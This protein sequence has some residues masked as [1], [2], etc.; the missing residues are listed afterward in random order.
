MT[1]RSY[2]DL[3]DSAT[4]FDPQEQFDR[5]IDE[6]MKG[7]S[8][9]EPSLLPCPFCGE[10]RIF[11][12]EPSQFFQ[13]GSINCPA[14][15]VVLPGA[16]SDADELIDLWNTRYLG[17]EQS[18][19]IDERTREIKAYDDQ[20]GELLAEA[21]ALPLEA[22]IKIAKAVAEDGYHFG[23]IGCLGKINE[24]IGEYTRG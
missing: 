10:K 24:I 18:D 22:R 19:M 1:D 3:S 6:R 2:S 12:N 16:T 11:L 7:M 8:Y 14:C 17:D 21:A 20:I 9:N 23:G 4:T 13:Y 15:L 5:D